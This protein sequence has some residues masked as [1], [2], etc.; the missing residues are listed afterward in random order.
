MKTKFFIIIIAGLVMSL[1]IT[2]AVHA[3]PD[4]FY[5]SYYGNHESYYNDYYYDNNSYDNDYY[6]EDYNN[7]YSYKNENYNNNDD[8]G[9]Y[10]AGPGGY[11]G[12]DG[13]TFYYFDPESGYSYMG[14]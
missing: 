8:S 13:D 6:Y 3:C 11:T 4:C 14:N 12:S 7:N 9:Y 10:N 5:N 2:E 1:S